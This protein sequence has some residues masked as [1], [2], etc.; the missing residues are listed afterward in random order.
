MTYNQYILKRKLEAI[1]IFPFIVIGQCIALLQP[2]KKSYNIFFFFPFY[3]TGGAEK[4][5]AQIAQAIGNKNCIIYFT[6]KSADTTFLQEFI[7][8]SCTIKDISKFTD[9]KWLYFLNLIY[10]GIIITYINKQKQ[11]PIVFNGQC[12]FAYK[13]SPWVKTSIKQ[14]ELIH[15]F[16]SFSWIRIPFL[17]FIHS[18]IMISKVR[19]DNHLQQYAQLKVP[20]NYHQKIKYIAN[21]IN[22]PTNYTNKDVSTPLKILYVGRGTAEKRVHLVATIAEELHQLNKDITVTL[23]GNVATA[24]PNQLKNNCIFKGNIDNENL[25][26]DLYKQAHIL[27]ITSNTEGFPIVVME[28]M[29][30]GCAIIATPVGDIPIHITNTVNGFVAN[31]INDEQIVVEQMVAFI[32]Q[33]N[34]QRNLLAAISNNNITY[35]QEHFNIKTFQQQYLTLLNNT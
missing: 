31:T 32:Q 24:I 15:S 9:N 10:R 4:V 35:A 1:F 21:G 14:F 33:L 27:L 13:I 3:H 25:L 28:A 11:S 2:Q 19:I 8:S 26:A 6:R 7:Q 34:Q 22:L 29:A 30:Y 17:P 12:N 18:T 20:A 5:H 16:N 23:V